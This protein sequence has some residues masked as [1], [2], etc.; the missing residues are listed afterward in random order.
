MTFLK[1]FSKMDND[2]YQLKNNNMV[3]SYVKK[4]FEKHI[5]THHFLI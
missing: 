3:F 4:G 5:K 1:S 2:E